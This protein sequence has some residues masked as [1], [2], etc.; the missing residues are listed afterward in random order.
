MQR[1]PDI[2]W[3]YNFNRIIRLFAG[4]LHTR[5][6]GELQRYAN[7]RIRI[8]HQRRIH[9]A[10]VLTRQKFI[11]SAYRRGSGKRFAL[12]VHTHSKSF[13]ISGSKYKKLWTRVNSMIFF[14]I[15]S[16]SC[17]NQ[18]IFL[19]S[20]LLVTLFFSCTLGSTVERSF[21]FFLIRVKSV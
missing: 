3:L 13:T 12:P 7:H 10:S 6:N 15:P 4:T 20:W 1:K 5:R 18:L 2:R 11:R 16:P 8:H 9:I 21:L 14:P 19:I 17:F